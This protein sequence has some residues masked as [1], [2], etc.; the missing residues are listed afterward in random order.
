MSG[1][2]KPLLITFLGS[3]GSGKSY[4]ARQLAEKMNIPR[5]NPDT[6]RIAMLGSIEALNAR[7]YPDIE[8]DTILFKLLNYS[9]QEILRS[10]KSVIYD[11]ARHNGKANREQTRQLA[12][13]VDALVVYVWIDT[14]REVATERALTREAKD[15]QRTLTAE[16]AEETM[17]FHFAHFNA[18]EA[19][20]L[21]I[22][23]SGQIPFEQQLEI[24]QSELQ[25]RL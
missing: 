21:A 16:R 9:I 23:I 10:G 14:P 12:E 11:T 20:E 7:P 1:S 2:Q 17:D 25:I 4:F 3:I 19:D 5:I 13:S 6:A 22:K 8:Y 18:P 15:D 24:F